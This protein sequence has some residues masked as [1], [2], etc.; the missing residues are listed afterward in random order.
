MAQVR[1]SNSFPFLVDD[2]RDYV[3]LLRRTLEK[4][5]IPPTAIRTCADGDEAVALLAKGEWKPSFTLLDVRMPGRSGLDVLEWIRASPSLALHPVFM[6]TGS[7]HPDHV[8]KAFHLGV[9]SYFIKPT[10]SRDL[11]GILEG[12]LAY[13]HRH[14]DP[15]VI[16]TSLAPERA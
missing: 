6:M 8:G 13:S 16:R 5:G 7:S 12:I 9:G 14:P 10:Q 1:Y 2:D 3:R 11:E 15:T 4:I